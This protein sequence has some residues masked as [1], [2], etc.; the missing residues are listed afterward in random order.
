MGPR[1]SQ[2]NC[3]QK[4][5]FK[6]CMSC[7][8]G[9]HPLLSLMVSRFTISQVKASLFSYCYRTWIVS[10]RTQG[11]RELQVKSEMPE[12][13]RPLSSN[14]FPPLAHRGGVCSQTATCSTFHCVESQLLNQNE[15]KGSVE[16][17]GP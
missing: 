1:G 6:E 15:T 17:L 5:M 9:N 16:V 10:I 4:E 14:H 2:N 7:F 3:F 13:I 11:R 12:T 8:P